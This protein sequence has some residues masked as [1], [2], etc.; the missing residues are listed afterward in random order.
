[1]NHTRQHKTNKLGFTTSLG[2]IYIFVLNIFNKLNFAKVLPVLCFSFNFGF[3]QI[4]KRCKKEKEKAE[5]LF[6]YK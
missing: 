2:F 3:I 4:L 6:I 1:M 5:G